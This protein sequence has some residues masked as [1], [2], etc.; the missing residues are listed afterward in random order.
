MQKRESPAIPRAL[1]RRCQFCCTV[2]RL[3]RVVA[4]VIASAPAPE[5]PQTVDLI[6]RTD[7]AIPLG[8]IL[9]WVWD[10]DM[11]FSNICFFAGSSVGF[12]SYS[13]LVLFN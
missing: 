7:M 3:R 1:I 2:D 5:K 8:V 4:T 13:T 10:W 6:L 12:R 9:D 11:S